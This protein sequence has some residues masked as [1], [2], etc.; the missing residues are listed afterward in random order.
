MNSALAAAAAVE[1]EEE[2]GEMSNDE[3]VVVAT[4]W[5]RIHMTSTKRRGNLCY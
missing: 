5:K 2:D 1:G 4:A 3:R